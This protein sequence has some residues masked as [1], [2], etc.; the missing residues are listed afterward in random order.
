MLKKL[1]KLL[2]IIVVLCSFVLVQPSYSDE[3][4]LRGGISTGIF[5]QYPYALDEATD[6][7]NANSKY[8]H[9]TYGTAV[10]SMDDVFGNV[11]LDFAIQFGQLKGADN[12]GKAIDPQCVI[13]SYLG[14]LTY[15]MDNADTKNRTTFGD[16]SILAN[17]PIGNTK[18]LIGP[19]YMA[20]E[21]DIDAEYLEGQWGNVIS[22]NTEFT[23]FGFKVGAQH[24]IRLKHGIA[25]NFESLFG[26]YRGKRNLR[27]SETETLDGV[28]INRFQETQIKEIVNVF[29]GDFTGSVSKEV[30]FIIP[31]K[32]ELGVN[33]KALWSVVDTRNVVK[34]GTVGRVKAFDRG[35]KYDDIYAL[36]GFAGIVIPF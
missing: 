30:S 19:S 35:Q 6:E 31:V 22:R 27:I 25:F 21:N 16:A 1:V 5:S 9:G 18:L 36:S 4:K 23:G 17:L 29:T 34:I 14:L 32:L 28:Y 15:C 3:L 7:V 10:Y 13:R 24:V 33:Y 26:F 20:F 12:E 2:S 8:G 11:G